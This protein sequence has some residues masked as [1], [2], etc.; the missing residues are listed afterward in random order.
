MT[1]KK[2]L[3]KRLRIVAVLQST[4]RD[5]L[6]RQ[7]LL[8]L[9]FYTMFSS[10]I[11]RRL[12]YLPTKAIPLV[13]SWIVSRL[14]MRHFQIGYSKVLLSSTKVLLNSKTAVRFLRLRHLLLLSVVSPYR[15]CISMKPHSLN[16]GM[17]S[18][19]QFCLLLFLVTQ[20]RCCLH[21]LRTG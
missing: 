1:I 5:R 7:R 4:L 17:T 16:T 21:L 18:L 8:L 10:T 19:H 11:T 6:A 13:K 3:S 12:L 15:F 2:K 9:L 20:P 14:L